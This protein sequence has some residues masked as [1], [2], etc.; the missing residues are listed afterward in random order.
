MKN[1]DYINKIFQEI[2]NQVNIILNEQ[3]GLNRSTDIT[4]GDKT[5]YDEEKEIDDIIN[6]DKTSENNKEKLRD[7]R[8]DILNGDFEKVIPE[9]ERKMMEDAYDTTKDAMKYT[10]KKGKY[11]GTII[12]GTYY[13][14]LRIKRGVSSVISRRK[15]P[16]I[17]QAE[18]TDLCN[19]INLVSRYINDTDDSTTKDTKCSPNWTMCKKKFET[20]FYQEIN[21]SLGK[22]EAKRANDYYKLCLSHHKKKFLFNWR[23][24]ESIKPDCDDWNKNTKSI[25]DAAVSS[26]V[27]LMSQWFYIKNKDELQEKSKNSNTIA[28]QIM[29]Y[30]EVEL[31]FKSGVDV[32]N[33]SGHSDCDNYQFRINSGDTKKFKIISGSSLSKGK[34]VE[35]SIDEAGTKYLLLTFNTLDRGTQQSSNLVFIQHSPHVNKCKTVN[36]KFEIVQLY[37]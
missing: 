13:E 2:N 3:G 8:D 25:I 32:G 9:E 12:T 21:S 24:R 16:E 11:V 19:C 30:Q 6:K 15:T 29:A 35:L 10:I 22:E 18:S 37:N 28:G 23:D 1:I 34:T 5:K 33:D 4:V 31:K 27:S 20:E 36:T 14:Y 17:F 7:L 26:L